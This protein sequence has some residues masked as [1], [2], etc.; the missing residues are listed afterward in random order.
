[1]VSELAVKLGRDFRAQLAV[2]VLFRVV[3]GSEALIHQG[4]KHV[5]IWLRAYDIP[6]S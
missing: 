1:M 5:S 4:W 6:L 3:I 2:L